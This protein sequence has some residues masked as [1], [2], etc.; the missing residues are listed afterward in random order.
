M[1]VYTCALPPPP[2]LSLSSSFSV[3]FHTVWFRYRLL[4]ASGFA[5][6]LSEQIE[7]SL[8]CGAFI[9][10]GAEEVSPPALLCV[11]SCWQ[12]GFGWT[13]GA[14]L[15]LLHQYGSTL[16][17]GAGRLTCGLLLPL[18]IGLAVTLL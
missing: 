5:R 15:Q 12:L 11:S 9:A 6:R 7:D 17:A 4:F 8:H 18:A 13:N 14:A 16:A 1:L 2:P 10:G 3:I